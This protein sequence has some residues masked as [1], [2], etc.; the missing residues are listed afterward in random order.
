MASAARSSSLGQPGWL[1]NHWIVFPHIC[2]KQ[3]TRLLRTTICFNTLGDERTTGCLMSFFILG[4]H[5]FFCILSAIQH[6]WEC[7]AGEGRKRK[8]QR[9][10]QMLE[11]MS[12]ES[13]AWWYIGARTELEDLEGGN[14]THCRVRGLFWDPQKRLEGDG[15]KHYKVKERINERHSHKSWSM[16]F[17]GMLPVCWVIPGIW[18]LRLLLRFCLYQAIWKHNLP[19]LH[20]GKSASM[21]CIILNSRFL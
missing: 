6:V 14:R 18:I 11:S 9:L 15:W 19:G 13:A 16:Y 10:A 3:Y 4:S 2:A 8:R 7:A 20:E 1:T 17:T 21:L 5:L 12:A